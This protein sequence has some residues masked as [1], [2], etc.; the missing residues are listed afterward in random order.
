MKFTKASG[1]RTGGRRHRIQHGNRGRYAPVRNI[2]RRVATAFRRV[3]RHA[4]YAHDGTCLVK[5]RQRLQEGGDVARVL[6]A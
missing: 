1:A 3:G 4:K 2:G 5:V 6:L